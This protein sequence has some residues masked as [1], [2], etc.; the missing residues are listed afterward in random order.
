MSVAPEVQLALDQG[1]S[2]TYSVT[3][4]VDL[5]GGSAR[6]V[7]RRGGPDGPI[8]LELTEAAGITLNSTGLVITFDPTDTS[9]MRG[10][11]WHALRATTAG[12]TVQGIFTG[13]LF[14]SAS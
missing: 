14:V 5:T 2:F 8:A 12:G 11:Y 10:N 13:S 4:G 9:R 3:T 7:A 1:E 6:Y